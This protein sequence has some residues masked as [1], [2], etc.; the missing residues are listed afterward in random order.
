MIFTNELIEELISCAKK[1]TGAPKNAGI[2]RGSKKT[3]FSMESLDGE[4]FFTG[5]IS[6]NIAFQENFSIGLVY[7]PKDE[8]S[9]LVL[10]PHHKGPHIH[11]ATAEHIAAGLK[12]E[13]G[14]IITDVPYT[15]IEDAIQHYVRF[16]NIVPVDRQKHF[17]PPNNQPELPF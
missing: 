14:Q 4:H 1:I 9:S 5:F 3:K 7:Y 10:A 12:P 13:S 15:T 6:E 2:G 16:I 17:P 8:K 11:K